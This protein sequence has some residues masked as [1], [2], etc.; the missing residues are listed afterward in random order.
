MIVL[1]FLL[2]ISVMLAS[3]AACL[4]ADE[5]SLQDLITRANAA[6]VKDQ[7]GLYIKIAERQL[8]SAEELYNAGKSADARA[9]IADVVTYSE[10]AHNAAVESGKR[11][12]PTEMASRKMSHQLRDLKRTLDYEDQAPVQAAADRLETLAQDLLNHMFGKDK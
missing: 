3:V 7:P 11:L 5:Q 9:A 1:K 12:K 6:P 10:K 8:K 2:I 4:A